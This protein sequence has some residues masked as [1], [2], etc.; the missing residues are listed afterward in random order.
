VVLPLEF[1]DLFPGRWIWYVWLP[2]AAYEIPLALWLL[3]K[4]AA[5]PVPNGAPA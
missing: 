5:A 4:G 3:I 2:L 1:V